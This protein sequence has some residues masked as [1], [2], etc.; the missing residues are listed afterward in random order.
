MK[1]QRL[2]RFARNFCFF[3]FVFLFLF[4]FAD[5]SVLL[6]VVISFICLFL[7]S[8]V[9][10]LFFTSSAGC[11]QCEE[12]TLGERKSNSPSLQW[13]RSKRL[14]RKA[15][16]F[17]HRIGTSTL[18]L[19][20]NRITL[21]MGGFPFGFPLRQALNV[22]PQKSIDA[23]IWQRFGTRD[24]NWKTMSPYSGTCPCPPTLYY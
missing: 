8:R 11:N 3:S 13:G 16:F 10:Q 24:A 2:R 23:L 18:G 19:Y 21:K 12:S 15:L 4:C 7:F 20:Q 5:C 17:N 22:Y 14:P 1:V 6:Q 9:V